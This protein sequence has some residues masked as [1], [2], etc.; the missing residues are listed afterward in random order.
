M[1]SK[2]TLN[3]LVEFRIKILQ[4]FDFDGFQVK[5]IMRVGKKKVGIKGSKLIFETRE[6]AEECALRNYAEFF[7]MC[8]QEIEKTK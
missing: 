1:Q 6:Q 7:L 3:T 8:K 4:S 5:P 2:E